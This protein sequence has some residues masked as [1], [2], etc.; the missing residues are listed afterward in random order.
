[1][2][3]TVAR[4]FPS[5][6]KRLHRR[7]RLWRLNPLWH[8][9]LRLAPSIPTLGALEHSDLIRLSRLMDSQ[10]LGVQIGPSTSVTFT[11]RR[12]RRTFAMPLEEA[13]YRAY[14]TCRTST[15]RYVSFVVILLVWRSIYRICTS[16]C[17]VHRPGRGSYILPCRVLSGTDT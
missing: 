9:P 10:L 3:R 5:L 8:S 4:T 12:Q 11:P 17:N 14:G 6:S 1:M 2:A 16:V 13:C 15:S 7:L